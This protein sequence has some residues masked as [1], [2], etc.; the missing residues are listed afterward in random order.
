[1]RDT[2]DEKQ[3]EIERL[4]DHFAIVL[5]MPGH[6]IAY[7]K[8]I[9]RALWD[10]F[11]K[12]TRWHAAEVFAEVLAFHALKTAGMAIDQA[13]F[14]QASAMGDMVMSK[15]HWLLQYTRFRVSN[16]VI[17][18]GVTIGIEVKHG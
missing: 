5:G 17:D 7:A 4:F 14:R 9:E 1:M 2:F 6:A 3:A 8:A 12:C 18:I 11:P 13:A 16:R 10:A 15:R